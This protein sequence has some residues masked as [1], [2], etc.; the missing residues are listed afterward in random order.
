MSATTRGKA[1]RW[2]AALSLALVP[3][4][5]AQSQAPESRPIKIAVDAT[6]A[7]QKILHA[8]LEIPASP[9]PLTLFYSKWLP[10]DHSPDG[11]IANLTGLK[12]TSAG[13]PIPWRR[14][15]V[16]M[17]AFHLDVPECASS[18]KVDLDFLLSVPGPTI[19]FSASAS[20][21][22]LILMWNQRI[23]S[24]QNAFRSGTTS[25][26]RLEIQHFPAHRQPI[27]QRDQ[28]CS[29]SPR[30]S[31]GL[32]RAIRRIHEDLS[33]YAREKPSARSRCG[34]R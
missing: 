10:A 22:L 21:K 30:P 24:R 2:I 3:A 34:R 23:A 17:Y 18:V 15:L 12:F 14:D 20:A 6:H 13:K 5:R 4:C 8:Q 9:G 32:S 31:G 7:T 33:S 27:R 28:I 16:D 29:C 19:D 25:P 26:G 11:P 1:L